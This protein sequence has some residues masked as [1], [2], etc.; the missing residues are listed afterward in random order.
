MRGL[1][2]VAAVAERL[3]PDGAGNLASEALKRLNR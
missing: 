1:V 2:F 3:P